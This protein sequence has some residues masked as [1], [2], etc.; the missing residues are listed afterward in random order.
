MAGR[1]P[2]TVW[3]NMAVVVAATLITAVS[4]L[5]IEDLLPAKPDEHAAVV[6][7]R[8]LTLG[9]LVV[10]LFGALSW[11]SRVHRTTGTLFHLQLLDEGMKDLSEP[12]RLRAARARMAVRSVTRWVD[13]RC[14]VS[15]HGTVDVV[16]LTQSLADILEEQINTDLADTGYTVAPV[17][18]W[19]MA[20]AIGTQL[21]LG[22]RL[23]LLELQDI[24]GKPLNEIRLDQP[25]PPDVHV[26][27]PLNMRPATAPRRVGVW[28]AVTRAAA[29]NDPGD[30]FAELGVTHRVRL[31]LGPG[32]PPVDRTLSDDDLAGLGAALAA[33]LVAVCDTFPDAELVVVA[34]V[35]KI[36]AMATG[37]HLAQH[38]FRFFDRT[39]LLWF[40]RPRL[41]PMRVRESQPQL[42]QA[43]VR[44]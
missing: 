39:H 14:R 31:T 9:V 37:W 43:G 36:V 21:P 41:V 5:V 2:R 4:G 23:G 10:L 40:D 13:L 8:V 3:P 44:A 30:R 12:S 18:P 33:H 11:R 15:A 6:W 20:L 28:I 32:L 26:E 19:P 42:V 17:M 24:D 34:M 1:I 38:P 27:P 22:D 29:L 25:P 16:D 35:P 7:E